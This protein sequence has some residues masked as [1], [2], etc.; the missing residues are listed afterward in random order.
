MTLPSVCL[1]N[2]HLVPSARV[3]PI[4]G[5]VYIDNGVVASID[6]RKSTSQPADVRIDCSSSVA[7]PGLFNLHVHCRPE[8]A[9]SDGLPVPVWHQRVDLLSR[10]M[11]EQD[12]YVGGLIAYGELLLSGVTSSMVMTRH[13]ASAADAAEALGVRSVVVP[14]AGDGGGVDRGDLDD[15]DSSLQLIRD[16]HARSQ[17]SRHELWPGFDSPLTTS[18]DGMRNV[19]V[20]ASQLGVGIHT[21]MAETQYEVESFRAKRGMSEPS[22]LRDSGVLGEKTVLAHCNWLTDDDIDLMAETRTAVVH[23]PASNMRFSSGVCRVPELKEAGVRLALGTDGMLSG[24]QLNVFSAMRAAAMLHRIWTSDSNVLTSADVFSMVT[25][26]AAG[27][28]GFEGGRIAVGAAADIAVLD[29]T[30]IHLQP[31]RRDPLNDQDLLNLIVWCARPSDVQHVLCDG[32]LL[33]KDRSLQRVDEKEIRMRA[34][35]ADIRLRPLI[36]P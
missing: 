7:I 10:H 22:A 8:R 9:L 28:L 4:V 5:D 2:V 21:H 16:R 25:E 19:A 12:A 36:T 20:T 11:T 13:F 6:E 23:N 27:A 29:M 30:G 34:V 33:V 18:I 35:D 32:E 14:L 24:Y 31:Y 26:S 17:G 3:A 1:E 15:L